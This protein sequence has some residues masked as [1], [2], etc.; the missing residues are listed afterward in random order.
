MGDA[1]SQGPKPEL[2][3]RSALRMF[4]MVDPLAR[5]M[6]PVGMPTGAPNVLLLVRGRRTG[7]ERSVPVTLLDLDG[8]W[9]VQATYGAD[10]WGRNLRAAGEAVIVQPGGRRTAVSAKEVPIDDAAELLHRVLEPYRSPRL[11]R[12]LLGPNMRPP[13]GLLRRYRIRIDVTPEEYRTEAARHP[14]FELRPG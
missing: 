2:R 8:T 1:R 9:Y 5:R 13:V 14:L 6:I 12:R 10:G 11:L 3:I 4:R 7:I